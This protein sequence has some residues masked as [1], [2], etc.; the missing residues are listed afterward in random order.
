MAA[1]CVDEI[2][3][4]RGRRVPIMRRLSRGQGLLVRDSAE[5]TGCR[6]LFQLRSAQRSLLLLSEDSVRD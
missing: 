6:I 1:A 2:I 4:H 3:V 5:R